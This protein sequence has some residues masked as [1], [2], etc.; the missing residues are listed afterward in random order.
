MASREVQNLEAKKYQSQ[1]VESLDIV[2]QRQTAKNVEEGAEP[3]EN[4]RPNEIRKIEETWND[5]YKKC[6]NRG[7]E[8]GTQIL[9]YSVDEPWFD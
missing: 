2:T 5:I 8:T 6:D 7:S 9:E 1:L 4:S 3:G